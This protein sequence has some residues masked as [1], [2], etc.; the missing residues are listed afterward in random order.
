MDYKLYIHH[1]YTYELFWYFC[2]GLEILPKDV[3]IWLKNNQYNKNI[4]IEDDVI[5][6][7][8]YK[9]K[10]IKII[11]CN[12]N[13]WNELDGFHL[14]DYSISLLEENIVGD[15][16]F[17]ANDMERTS[18]NFRNLL[19]EKSKILQNRLHFMYIDWEGHDAYS[20]E[21]WATKVNKKIEFFVDETYS[22]N[23]KPKNSNFVFTNLFWSFI[24]PNTLGIREY[25]FFH[26]YLQYKNDYKYKINIPARRVYGMKKDVIQQVFKLNNPNINCT[27]GSFHDSSQYSLAGD[28]KLDVSFTEENYIEKRGYGI[29][30]WGGEWNDNNMNENMWKMFGISEVVILFEISA[31][32]LYEQALS[33]NEDKVANGMYPGDSMLTEKSI[34]HILVGK[35]FI[36]QHY[37]TIKFLDNI[38]K[39]HNSP[40]VEYPIKY[41]NI[42]DIIS[43]LDD[44]TKDDE[45]WIIFLNKLKAYVKNL[46][47]EL[48]KICSN[49]NS[50]FDSL[51]QKKLPSG[52]KIIL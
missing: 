24:Y 30:D 31:K 8:I 47:T 38:L 15:R 32:Y 34:S 27:R 25:Y 50:Y 2:H 46:R 45:K 49:N 17:N 16:G 40:I 9:N 4:K 1:Y 37:D 44:I 14:L 42:T 43:F 51:I 41:N 10:N 19:N 3:P 20:Q 52:N 6:D 35:P 5:I 33:K 7:G 28:G 11:F 13:H 21:G 22:I 12:D 23:K 29:H 18:E 26:D 48:V 39:E 36:P